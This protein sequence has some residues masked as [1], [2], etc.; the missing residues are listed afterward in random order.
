MKNKPF[1]LAK[2]KKAFVWKEDKM[3]W[4]ELFI[5]KPFFT[6]GRLDAKGMSRNHWLKL[7]TSGKNP[8]RK[9]INSQLKKFDESDKNNKLRIATKDFPLR[10]SG[11]G[12]MLILNLPD[13]RKIV[14]IIKRAK[15][16]QHPGKL[17]LP[18]GMSEKLSDMIFPERLARREI[19]EEI[20]IRI[21]KKTYEYKNMRNITGGFVTHK[22]LIHYRK[23]FFTYTGIACIDD[24]N[25]AIDTRNIF[26]ISLK[27]NNLKITDGEISFDRNRCPFFQ[28]RKISLTE[29]PDLFKIPY[30]N[31]TPAF[32]AVLEAIKKNGKHF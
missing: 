26:S 32:K 30:G 28:R 21:G 11:G 29:F 18:G 25:A 5:N 4:I 14:P 7:I 9:F 2:I 3:T 23:N 8:G 12:G 15:I 31:I 13:G 10:W 24:K 17:D 20:I 16:G 6:A 22:V 19:S 27:D 1:L